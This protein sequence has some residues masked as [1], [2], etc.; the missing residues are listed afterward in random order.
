[1]AAVEVVVHG[2]VQGVF[3]RDT[4]SNQAQAAG[5]SGWV[6]NDAAGTVTACFEGDRETI[7]ELVQWCRSG[8]PQAQ[9]AN[10]EVSERPQSGLSRFEVRD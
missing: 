5:L 7:D 6:R 10:V 3:F 2:H 9:V 1:M 4:C 8:P